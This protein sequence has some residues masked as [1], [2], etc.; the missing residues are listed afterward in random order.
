MA[1]IRINAL[2]TTATTPASDDFLALDGT[3]QGTRKI[4]ATNIANNVTDVVFGTSGPSAKSSIAARAARQG[5]VFDGTLGATGTAVTIG[6]ADLTFSQWVRVPSTVS[7]TRG[8]FLFSPAGSIG[9]TSLLGYVDSDATLNIHITG[10][11]SGDRTKQ[12]LS[13]FVTSY[14]GKWVN[15]LFTRVGSTWTG[16][17]NGVATTFSAS[18]SGTAPTW[19][20]SISGAVVNFGSLGSSGAIYNDAI[21][22]TLIYNRALTAAEVV[23]LY[24]SGVPAGADYNNASNTSFV[25]ANASAFNVAI[26]V[27]DWKTALG[28][29]TISGG[30]L[31]CTDGESAYLNGYSFT[32]GQKARFTVTVDSIT[33]GNAQYYN[34][35]AYV[36]FASAA[37]TY[38]VEF[39][40]LAA[41]YLYLKSNGGDAVF[42]T[43]LAYRVGLLLAPDAAQAGGG[44]TWYD[45]SGN[46]ANITLPASG[47]SW[48]VPSS[49][50]LGGNWT[51]SGNLTVSGTGTSSFNK[52]SSGTAVSFLSGNNSNYLDISIG[53][54]TQEHYL[55]VAAASG[56][57]VSGTVAGDFALNVANGANFVFGHA[58]SLLGTWK[59]NGNLLIGGVIDGGQKLQVNGAATF[60]GN[61]GAGGV[62]PVVAYSSGGSFYGSGAN[63]QVR[64]VATSTGGWAFSTYTNVSATGNWSAGLQ[65]TGQTY[66]ITNDLD[67]NGTAALSIAPTTLATTFGGTISTSAPTGGA[68]AWE[69]GVYTATAPTATGY[70]TIEIGGTQYKLLAATA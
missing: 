3:A 57:Y 18:T 67:L 48:N 21:S 70:V 6:T 12:T 32:A 58:G 16:Y 26:D 55:A 45:T 2:A 56:N 51:T 65:A 61:I 11:T 47:V 13:G 36:N 17:I 23:S 20:G 59:A 60:T 53:R 40:A 4:L 8:L 42:D 9:A 64:L 43:Y 31:T 1:D 62:N 46:A 34:G 54:A 35:S 10:A 50:V 28:T 41:T 44:L 7:A 52:G 63:P 25:P 38:T 14:A 29:P 27:G 24:E 5:L 49:R 66:R 19:A 30:K 69:L 39:T 15:I 37:G 22:A 33:A 68:G